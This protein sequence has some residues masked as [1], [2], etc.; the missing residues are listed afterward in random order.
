MLFLGE[1]LGKFE[2]KVGENQHRVGVSLQMVGRLVT[3]IVK[4]QG[5]FQREKRRVC[6]QCLQ[7]VGCSFYQR[8]I[9]LVYKQFISKHPA[10][11][12]H[13]IPLEIFAAFGNLF[14]NI[15]NL[16]IIHHFKIS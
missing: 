16:R 5:I 6:F 9:F 11:I 3:F 2:I 15:L 4:R 10:E 1:I 12:T 7:L 8:I 14:Y 13:H